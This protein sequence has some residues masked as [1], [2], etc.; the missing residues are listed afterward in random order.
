M[1]FVWAFVS[2]VQRLRDAQQRYARV[3]GTTKPSAD[4]K[5]FLRS[6][7]QYL[8][9]N[10][11]PFELDAALDRLEHVRRCLTH[12]TFAE[13]NEQLEVLS[14]SIEDQ[15]ARRYCVYVPVA[16]VNFARDFLSIFPESI[17][18]AFPSIS[19]DVI[20]ACECYALDRNSASVFH[21]MGILQRGLYALAN[22]LEV[23]FKEGIELENWKNIIDRIEAKIRSLEAMKKGKEKDAQLKFYSEAAVQF[24]YFKD[25]WR[26][27]VAHQREEYDSD[28]AHS[29]LIHVRDFMAQLATR[30]K[31]AAPKPSAE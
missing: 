28:Q 21:S 3:P 4:Q 1:E 14:E 6:L 12:G 31:E 2:A 22:D 11:S 23:E 25:A 9:K 18:K 27:H 13:L 10:V 5:R 19:G 24:R 29:V 26:N 16:K 8:E 15:F 17:I 30:L 7:L 20:E